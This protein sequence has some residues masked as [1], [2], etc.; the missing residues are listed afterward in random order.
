MESAG[1]SLQFDDREIAFQV[2][3]GL[4]EGLERLVHRFGPEIHAVA[5]SI[6]R[7]HDMADDVSAE[8]LSSAWQ[9]IGSLKDPARLRP[10][11]LRIATRQALRH[12]RHL[13]NAHLS[14]RDE[15]T[16]AA[17]PDIGSAVVDRVDV[18]RAMD[19]LSPRV[20]AVIALRYVADLSIDEISAAIGRSKNTVKSE[21]RTGLQRLRSDFAKKVTE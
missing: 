8:T 17:G 6:C 2:R 7:D 10:W 18:A 21:L 5:Y 20:R 9:H 3:S 12:V 4:V 1:S 19:R 11:L 15:Q 14:G 13:K 16:I